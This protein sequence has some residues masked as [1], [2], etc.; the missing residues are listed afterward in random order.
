MRLKHE[1]VYP[2]GTRSDFVFEDETLSAVVEVKKGFIDKDMINQLDHYVSIEGGGNLEKQ[3]S[4]I[5]VGRSPSNTTVL[6]LAKDRHYAIKLLDIDVP[7]R[8]RLCSNGT[9]RRARGYEKEKCPCCGSRKF[10][11]DSFLL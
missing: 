5:L 7:T 1:H 4:G 9:C 11:R 2:D 10:V 8:I 3:V 6:Q